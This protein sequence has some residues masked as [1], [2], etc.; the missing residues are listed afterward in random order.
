MSAINW[1][2]YVVTSRVPDYA[3][4]KGGRAEMI[5]N[6]KSVGVT[7][8][9]FD[10][11]RSGRIVDRDLLIALRD[12][13]GGADIVPCAGIMPSRGAS[14]L[15]G[16]SRW[17]NDLCYTDP[18]TWD[19]L[20]AAMELGAEL[21]DEFIIDDA[22]CTQCLCERCRN[23][24]ADR[25]WRDF[26]RDLLLDFT[27]NVIVGACKAKNPGIKMILKFPQWYDRLAIFGYDTARQPAEFEATWIGTETRD[28]DTPSTGYVHQ[29]EGC[30]NSRWHNNAEPD[31]EGAWFDPYGCDPIVYVE[32]AWQSVLGG[33]RTL[34]LFEYGSLFP[35][36]NGYL[37]AA[38]KGM[39]PRLEQLAAELDGQQPTGIVTVRP[40]DSQPAAD[41]YIF[42]GLGMVGIPLVPVA[43]WPTAPPPTLLLTD[44]V[45]DDADLASKVS[46]TVDAGGTVF[47]TASLLAQH[48]TDARLKE[49]AG[50]GP[51]GWSQPIRWESRHFFVGDEPAAAGRP[52]G[53]RFDLWPTTAEVLASFSCAAHRRSTRVPVV[54]RQQHPSGGAVVVLNVF[55]VSEL[56]YRLD[57]NL[58]V[59]IVLQM[60]HYPEPVVNVIQGLVASATGQA[61]LAPPKVAYYPFSGGDAALQNFTDKPVVVS[62]AGE[63][64]PA[65]AEELLGF[66]RIA[67]DGDG[68]GGR[69]V[70]IPARSIALIRS[71]R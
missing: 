19:E 13:F 39:M 29:Y 59:P 18:A 41:G 5:R 6:A 49:L 56:D 51:D 50:Y 8:A 4:D 23:A 44:H 54:T 36:K 3:P 7:K 58:N 14:E 57:E 12:D 37:I 69:R 30:F 26:R 45:A 42:D 20:R 2:M 28:P 24:K 38:L 61:F 71:A 63:P 33:M 68:D 53:F 52:V 1:V 46:Q 32:Q 21:F 62:A 15:G 22:F 67:D 65:E 70:R 48:D 55:G 25:S 34:M 27:K 66:A 35:E 9:Y 47:L 10:V 43:E 31:L 16:N 60:Q 11:W 64:I 40:H 17:G